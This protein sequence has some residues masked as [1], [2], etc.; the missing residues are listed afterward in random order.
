MS[1]NYYRLYDA[2]EANK[3]DQ[4]KKAVEIMT[5]HGMEQKNIKKQIGTKYKQQYLE[6]TG[7]EKIRL[8]NA[9]IMAYKAVGVS[10]TDANKII[11]GWK[12]K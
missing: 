10:E 8:K 1:G 3:S 11:N 2:I 7:N 5:K 9:L 4:I 12:Q 6:A